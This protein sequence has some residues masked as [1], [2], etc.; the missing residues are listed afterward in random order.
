VS[1]TVNRAVEYKE[2]ICTS[3]TT[4]VPRVIHPNPNL[5][6]KV[7]LAAKSS[8]RPLGRC[9]EVIHPTLRLARCFLCYTKNMKGWQLLVILMG[10]FA[11]VV[12]E[13]LYQL[14]VIVLAGIGILAFLSGL[15]WRRVADVRYLTVSL[16]LLLL[17]AGV[18]RT[19]WYE[20]Q[21]IDSPLLTQID[22]R[23][24]IVGTVSREPDKRANFTQLFVQ[25]DTDTVLV[26]ADR[27]ADVRYGDVVEMT[28]RIE[29]PEVFETDTNRVFDYPSYLKVRQVQF[30]MGFASVQLVD[31]GQGNPLLA[32]LYIAKDH[33]VATL[34]QAL[35]SPEVDLGVGLLLGVKQALGDELE[36]AFRQTGIIHIVVLSGYNV[37][38]V[39]GFFW[40]ISSWFLQIRGRIIFGLVGITLFALLVGLSATVV[41]ASIM[42]AILLIGKLMGRLYD[43]L[44][45]LLFAAAV[46]VLIN[47]YI[48]LYDIGFQLSFMAT[49]GLVL[50]LPQFESTLQTHATGLKLRDLFM[51]TLVTQLFVLPLLMFHIGEVSLVSVI[52]NMLVL[53]MVPIAMLGSFVTGLVGLVWIEAAALLGLLAQLPLTYIIILATWFARLPFA[54][55]VVPQIPVWVMLGMYLVPAGLFA[56]WRWSRQVGER[57]EVDPIADW[58]V[59]E[60]NA[61]GVDVSKETST[62]PSTPI[63]FR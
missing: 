48:L 20:Q 34:E 60:E 54:A 17:C 42:A 57:G 58:V 6:R 4:L 30:I 37:M 14:P 50:V 26:R 8:H 29:Q 2:K 27:F 40:W 21:F 9:P 49:L 25:T 31:R 18:V 16:C 12:I 3:L 32:G 7:L 56:W 55:V 24:T 22:E 53:P 10:F 62:P 44:R 33:F 41:R 15:Y 63:A 13:S 59:E 51:A 19:Q 28:G 45:A 38:L 1:R 47:P 23:V 35:P 52:V 5:M 36:T 39:V 61:S 11:G 43:V 46:M